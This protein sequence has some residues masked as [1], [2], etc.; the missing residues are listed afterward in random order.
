MDPGR[1]GHHGREQEL[2]TYSVGAA[3]G[4]ALLAAQLVGDADI[5]RWNPVKEIVTPRREAVSTYDEL[6]TLYR[7]LYASSIDV[8][9]ALAA[10]QG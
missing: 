6:Y 4:G 2:R 10:R 7:T 1:L 3:Y 8:T 5:D 9:H